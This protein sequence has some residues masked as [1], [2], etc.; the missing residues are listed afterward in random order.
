MEPSNF[1]VYTVETK[2][3]SKI[4]GHAIKTPKK[5]HNYRIY[6]KIRIYMHALVHVDVV[7]WLGGFLWYLYELFLLF[8]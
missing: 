4:C 7:Q 3:S 1:C 5:C 2:I 6:H 8:L